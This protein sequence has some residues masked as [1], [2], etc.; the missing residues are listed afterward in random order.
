MT[1]NSQVL[2][3]LNRISVQMGTVITTLRLIEDLIPTPGP[4]DHLVLTVGPVTT[5]GEAN[6]QI[7]DNQE[8]DI[9]VDAVD[10]KGVET[11][12]TF[13]AVSSDENV[14]T[15]VDAGD[16]KTFTLVAGM[17]GSAVVTVTEADGP[18]NVSEAVDVVPGDTATIQITEGPVSDQPPVE[19]PP[20]P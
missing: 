15:V 1:F 6:M 20:A 18:L 19:P 17:P 5:Q 13:A 14:V 4:P 10:S 7:K 3:T 9:T 2:A 12:D 8:F 11:P 16:G